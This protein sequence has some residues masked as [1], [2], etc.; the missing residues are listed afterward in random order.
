LAPKRCGRTGASRSTFLP[1]QIS[2]SDEE[3]ARFKI[4]AQAAALNHPNIATIH[5]IEEVEGDMFI[6]MEYIEGREMR[7]IAEVAGPAGGKSCPKFDSYPCA[8]EGR[9]G[10]NSIRKPALLTSATL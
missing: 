6:V 1:R 5:A 2:A 7:Q 8:I 3:R 4:E 10:R 9:C